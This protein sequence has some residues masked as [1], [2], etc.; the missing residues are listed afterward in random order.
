MVYGNVDLNT[1]NPFDAL[2]MISDL[3]VIV[4]TFCDQIFKDFGRYLNPTLSVMRISRY[5]LVEKYE[6]LCDDLTLMPKDDPE[7]VQE[8]SLLLEAKGRLTIFLREVLEKGRL[9]FDKREIE[10]KR[11]ELEAVYLRMSQFSDEAAD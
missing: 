6:R 9:H 7:W 5:V 1:S 2:R 8:A 4:K 3:T 11:R 10:L